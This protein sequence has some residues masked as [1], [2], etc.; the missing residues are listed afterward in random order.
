MNAPGQP[1]IAP[2][3]SS[4]AKDLVTTSLGP[5]RLWATL[6]HGIV[7]EVYYP[8]TGRPQIRDLGFIVAK[9]GAWFEVKRVNRYTLTLPEPYVPLPTVVHEG[10]DYRLTLEVL[11][12]PLRE[13]LLVRYALEGADFRLYPLLA[14]HLGPKSGD[15]TAWSEEGALLAAG[16]S[17]FLCLLASAGFARSS[18]GYVGVSD[19]WQDFSRNGAMTWTYG[20]AEHG[21]VALMGELN[22]AEGVIALGFAESPQGARTRAVSSLVEGF[23]PISKTFIA[24]WKAWGQALKL[25]TRKPELKR[26]AYLSAMT[27]KVHEDKSYPGAVVASMSIPWGSSH[28]DLGGYHLVWARDAVEAGLG[29]LATGQ[30]EDARRM[31]AYLCA[32]QQPDGHWYQNNYPDGAPYWTG[33]QL[34]EVGFPILLAEKLRERGVLTDLPS[35]KAMV[36]RAA[37]YLAQHGP[38][39][40][41]DRWEENAGAS[42]FTLAVEVAALVAAAGFLESVDAAYAL[43]LADHWNA[44]IE[45]WTYA[46]GTD[47]AAQAGVDGYYVRIVPPPAAGGLRGRI[48]VRNRVNDS[49]EAKELVSIDFLYLSRLGLRAAD[50]PKMRASLKVAEHVL[51]VDTPSG[52]SFHRYNG[53][54]YGEHPDGSPFDGTGVGRAWPLLTGERGHMA[55]QQGEDPTPYLMAMTKMT[56]PGGLIPEQVW[57]TDPLPEK[58]LFPGKPSGSA[59]PLVWAHAEFL[60]LL[61]A[62]SDRRPLELL[63]AVEKRYGFKAPKPRTWHW[64]PDTP[65]GTIPKGKELVVEAPRMFELEYQLDGE[66]P[67]RQAATLQGLGVY[68]VRFAHEL[69][70]GHAL[71]TFTYH[72]QAGQSTDAGRIELNMKPALTVRR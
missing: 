32:V 57:D 29:L 40:P 31:L 46:R 59:M 8:T 47:L 22:A 24:G 54:G 18:V 60:K 70:A 51:R 23:G 36:R 1:G 20:R 52:V 35:V 66:T 45:A 41:E 25:P 72:F 13:T 17:D 56:G 33:I 65:F 64:R 19:G 26:E 62:T 21:N 30:V 2:T 14:P 34:D 38:I 53:D 63:D 28:D 9:P 49:V 50:E 11:C 37:A 44:R 7:N 43:S 6:G 3:W 68:G 16:G 12:D 55:L 5:A 69:L 39:S 71:L 27:L 10:D 48:E 42:P 61:Q 58:L 4:S 67:Q 15:D